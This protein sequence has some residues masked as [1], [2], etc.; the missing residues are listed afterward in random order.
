M[1]MVYLPFQVAFTLQ[2]MGATLHV[3]RKRYRYH[4]CEGSE[5]VNPIHLKLNVKGGIAVWAGHDTERTLI[6]PDVLSVPE[7]QSVSL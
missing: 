4:A 3:G 7:S 5:V 1:G 2:I 6:G